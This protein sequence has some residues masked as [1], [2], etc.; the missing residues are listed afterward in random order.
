MYTDSVLELG[1]FA[2]FSAVAWYEGTRATKAEIVTLDVRSDIL[3]I[4]RDFF[5]ELAV[6]DRITV[7]EGPAART[8]VWI[9]PTGKGLMTFL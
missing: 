6:E 2:G 8:S 4:A 1:T 5:K 7:V 9:S 3:D